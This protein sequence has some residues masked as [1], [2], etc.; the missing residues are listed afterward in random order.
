MYAVVGCGECS[1]LW[2][3][4]GR[5]ETSECPRCGTRR[6]F[7]ARKKFVETADADHAR[8]VRASMLAN[9]QGE[10][11]AFAA[12]DSVAEL[13]SQVADGVVDDEEYLEASGLDVEE[14]EAAGE[15]DP[16][17]SVS[18]GSRKEIV[19]HAIDEL[20]RP[21][22]DEVVRYAEDRGVPPS[23]VERAL[24]KLVRNGEASLSR[25]EYRLL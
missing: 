15:R 12:I 3:V 1:N 16:H 2:I 22:E 6:P 14:L 8:E 24:E 18:S 17:G 23:Y 4:E 21:T 20:G 9:R 19:E 13:D 5:S 7:D 10:G 25:G 11:E